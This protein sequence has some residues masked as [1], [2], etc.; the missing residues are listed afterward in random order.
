MTGALFVSDLHLDAGRP[1]AT[2]AFR[3][4]LAG[5]ARDASHLYILGDLFEF[6]IGDDDDRPLAREVTGALAAYTRAGNACSVMRGNRDFLL[7]PRFAAMTGARLLPDPCVQEVGGEPVLLMH[8]DLLCT[9]DHSYQRYR[10]RISN[11][12]LQRLFLSLPRSWRR[13][14]G[15]EGRRRS[16]R[17]AIGRPAAFMDVNAATVADAMRQA[18]VRTLVHGHTHRPAIHRLEIDGKPATRA[19]LGDWYEQGSVLAWSATGPE[20]HSR[21]FG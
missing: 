17:H 5:D 6:W 8:G 3:D 4:F 1:R 20:L 13:A 16:R 7:G 9:D 12:W 21:A 15:A 2:A 10:K 19:V 14:A 18:G 11:P